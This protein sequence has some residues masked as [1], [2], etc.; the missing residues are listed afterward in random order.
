LQ[1]SKGNWVAYNRQ[2][3]ME[4]GS[5]ILDAY[6]VVLDGEMVLLYVDQY[7]FETLLTPVGFSCGGAYPILAP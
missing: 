4:Y 1:D 7:S 6:E 3:S 2:G 5:T